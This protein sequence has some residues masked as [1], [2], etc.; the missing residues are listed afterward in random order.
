M[1]SASDCKSGQ[2][3]FKS[4][5]TCGSDG[6]CSAAG[7]SGYCDTTSGVCTAC[8]IDAD[9][10]NYASCQLNLCVGD[11]WDGN[12][13]VC[14]GGP[15]HSPHHPPPPPPPSCS[16]NADCISN[17]CD[18][19]TSKC[20]AGDFCACLFHSFSNLE[21]YTCL[22][23]V[24]CTL[25]ACA[26]GYTMPANY[27]TRAFSFNFISIAEQVPWGYSALHPLTAGVEFALQTSV[28]QVITRLCSLLHQFV[29]HL[30]A[31]L[32]VNLPFPFCTQ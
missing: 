17:V 21:A 12:A 5:T 10:N 27:L 24:S 7:L 14:G 19:S 31:I 30:L 29:L 1:S 6:D 32:L 16:A 23:P 2:C 20:A 8:A 28:L 18:T 4:S 15:A 25:F 11:S 9:C 26:L 13:G 3:I 22:S